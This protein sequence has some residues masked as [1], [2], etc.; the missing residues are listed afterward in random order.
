MW[1][2]RVRIS[3]AFAD[4]SVKK[5]KSVTVEQN[6]MLLCIW[7]IEMSCVGERGCVCQVKTSVTVLSR[8]LQLRKRYVEIMKFRSDSM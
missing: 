1:I 5:I 2:V 4:L 3:K 6:V 8:C 7:D